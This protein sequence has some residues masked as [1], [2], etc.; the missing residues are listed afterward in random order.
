MT[1]LA[2]HI[3][4]LIKEGEQFTYETFATLTSRGNAQSYSPEWIVFRQRALDI[5]D[6]LGRNNDA[7]KTIRRG[8]NAT[9]LGNGFDE[10][11]ASKLSI[12]NGLRAAAHLIGDQPLKLPT[13]PTKTVIRSNRVFIVH[14]HDHVA[15]SELE[16]YLT[17][18]GLEP[19]VLHRQADEGKTVIEKFEK[20]SDVGYAFIIL[21]P[22]EIAY[23][24]SDE[25]VADDKRRKERR[26][27]PNVV[28]E[29]GYFIGRLGRENVCCLYTGEVDL[30]SDVS[31]ILYK[32]F[33]T[34]V[35]EIFY[36]IRK[37]LLQRNYKLK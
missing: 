34:H 20:H 16:L 30:P 18:L 13:T 12:V 9:L 22:D 28:L 17:E 3:Q 2:T 5:A 35:K 31:G 27:R 11:Q 8:L 1:D 23:P 26:P 10:F 19:V 29:F 36:D 7:A 24:I 21:T 15:K 14:G 37:E 25:K 6:E 33:H 32:E 4:K